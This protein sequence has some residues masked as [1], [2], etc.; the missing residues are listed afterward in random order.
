MKKFVEG[1]VLIVSMIIGICLIFLVEDSVHYSECI[2]DKKE[3]EAII[4]K[5]TEV[6]RLLDALDFDEEV[7]FL[8]IR[9]KFF[10]IRL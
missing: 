4:A 2:I 6:P 8:I 3:F 9:V 10:I 7:L 1:A 5:R